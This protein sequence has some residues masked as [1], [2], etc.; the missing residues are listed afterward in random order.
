MVEAA[1]LRNRLSV[2][3]K[4]ACVGLGATSCWCILILCLLPFVAARLAA[5]SPASPRS[6]EMHAGASALSISV[7]LI[8][9]NVFSL[10]VCV[11]MDMARAVA[12]AALDF[13]VERMFN[14]GT[15]H[16]P[17]SV[18]GFNYLRHLEFRDVM[19]LRHS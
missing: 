9:H 7:A 12:A 4:A 10:P 18:T 16:A 15:C 6:T 13:S 1:G 14:L 11:T 5:L 3:S 17:C 8:G 19:C 2:A